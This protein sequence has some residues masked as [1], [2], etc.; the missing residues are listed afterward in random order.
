[1]ICTEENQFV[2]LLADNIHTHISNKIESPWWP[3]IKNER[4]TLSKFLQFN[5]P[6]RILKSFISFID[7]SALQGFTLFYSHWGYKTLSH[8][9]ILYKQIP[10]NCIILFRSQL[11]KD[12]TKPQQTIEVNLSNK[13]AFIQTFNS[14]LQLLANHYINSFYTTLSPHSKQH[15]NNFLTWRTHKIKLSK[16]QQKLPELQDIF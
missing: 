7:E 10:N 5:P 13:S 1:M 6:E 15:Y 3:L 16:L 12:I 4:F 11:D 9:T 8:N 2:N 14:F